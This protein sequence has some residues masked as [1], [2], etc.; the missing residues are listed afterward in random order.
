METKS[1][2]NF[3]LTLFMN[4]F[5]LDVAYVSSLKILDLSIN[6]KVKVCF[7]LVSCLLPVL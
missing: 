2:N 4:S 7:G 5:W 3:F 6:L 1:F